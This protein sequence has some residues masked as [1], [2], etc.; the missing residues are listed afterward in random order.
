[1][2]ELTTSLL[3]L[4]SAFSSSPATFSVA[5][6]QKGTA[7]ATS[8][9]TTLS[10]PIT[11]EAYVREYFKDT[12][13]LAEIARCESTY[14]QFDKNGNALKGIANSGDIG[15]MQINK[16]YHEEDASKLGLDIYTLDGNLAFAQV[17]Y[18]KYGSDP[19]VSSSKCW[20]KS[21]QVAMR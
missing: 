8:A 12:P 20:K 16:Y 6:I 7:E 1:M 11:V 14:R 19:W 5:D 4:A 3:M 15:V 13:I 18:K 10:Q 17:L 21:A 2:F 9:T